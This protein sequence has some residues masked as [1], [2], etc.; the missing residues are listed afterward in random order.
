MWQQ[1]PGDMSMRA[2]A[3]DCRCVFRVHIREQEEQQQRAASAFCV[4]AP[5]HE[6]GVLKSEAHVDVPAAIARIIL[7]GEA[8]RKRSKSSWLQPASLA[9]KRIISA[10]QARG[11]RG[12]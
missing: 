8:D 11:I 6:I 10:V 1:L 3:D 5:L 12:R 4:S 9:G 2:L 7:G